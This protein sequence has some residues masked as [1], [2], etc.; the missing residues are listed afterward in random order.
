MPK[1]QNLSVPI[2]IVL[3]GALVAGALYFSGRGAEPATNTVTDT[4]GGNTVKTFVPVSSSDHILGNP[5]API[6]IVEYTDLECPFCKQFHDTMQQVMDK[7]GKS[8]QVMWVLR[9]FPLVQLHPNA[10]KIALAAECV[11][12][13]GG[14]TAYWNFISSLFKLASTASGVGVSESTFNACV[15][16]G[17][18]NAKVQKEYADAIA[19][20]GNGTPYSI[21]VVTKTGKTVAIPGSQPLAELEAVIEEALK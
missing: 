21:L 13:L 15:A 1:E 8:G 16:A 17:K 19:A 14:N 2:A 12:E 7:Y 20:G 10:P 5:K 4:T 18:Y 3:A 6:A 9:N 11:A